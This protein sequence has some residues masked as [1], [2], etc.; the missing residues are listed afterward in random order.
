LRFIGGCGS[1]VG[2]RLV[3]DSLEG[4]VE[5]LGEFA[6]LGL[7][8]DLDTD[9]GKKLDSLGSDER[10]RCDE[11]AFCCTFEGELG[12]EEFVFIEG[13]DFAHV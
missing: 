2:L 11:D 8:A 3:E 6:P 10:G 1:L 7:G 13:D 9:G 5:G 12:G 4:S